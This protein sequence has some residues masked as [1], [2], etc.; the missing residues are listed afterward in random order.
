MTY[1][2]NKPEPQFTDRPSKT[3]D[4]D[5]SSIIEAKRKIQEKISLYK[6][7]DWFMAENK[8]ELYAFFQ[9][10]IPLI[11][12][13]ARELGWSAG[14]HGSM[15]RDLD[16]IAIPWVTDAASKDKLATEIALAVCG[17]A[18]SRYTWESKP[19]GRQATSISACWTRTPEIAGSGHIDLSVIDIRPITLSN[20]L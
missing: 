17:M 6:P 3:K 11:Q 5:I 14:V 16:I 1:P 7:G 8:D 12:K 13:A 19:N 15:R 10:R 20:G 2:E 18:H 9:S 4:E